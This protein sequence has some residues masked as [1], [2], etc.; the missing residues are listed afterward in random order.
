MALAF[1]MDTQSSAQRPDRVRA[2]Q[3]RECIRILQV[4]GRTG[5]TFDEISAFLD[6]SEP[7]NVAY[8][9]QIL[10]IRF[11]V[12]RERETRSQQLMSG[13]PWETI[14]LTT[15]SKDRRVFPQ[16]LAEARDI[17]M[18]GQ[19]G[20]LVIHTPWGIEWKPFGLPRQK[21]PLKSVVLD[22]GV[23]E[24]VEK[25]V[26]AF[27]QRRQWYADRGTRSYSGLTYGSP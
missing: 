5:Y 23:A 21:R 26:S 4:G 8:A 3:K 13:I 11:Q 22:T 7:E 27:L 6:T 10:N 12:K 17:A 15:L 1:V 9:G 24:S 20:K 19:E 16:L 14:T 25:D 2:A 18:R